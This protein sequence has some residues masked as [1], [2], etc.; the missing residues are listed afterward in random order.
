MIR[1]FHIGPLVVLLAGVA[2]A[3]QLNVSVSKSVVGVDEVF[4][5]QVTAQ[6]GGVS[7]P[8]VPDSDDFDIDVQSPS[9]ST[10]R[11]VQ[12]INGHVSSTLKSTWR[13]RA[14]AKRKGKF[15]LPPITVRIDGKVET[16]RDIVITVKD[17][18]PLQPRAA[19]RRSAP[20]ASRRHD[21]PRERKQLTVDDIVM[22]ESF[23][24][25]NEVYQ[26]ERLLL[27]WRFWLLDA[28]RFGASR[29]DGRPSVE[30]FYEGPVE[31]TQYAQS[32]DGYDYRVYEWRQALYAT[33]SGDYAIG[34]WQWNGVVEYP[35]PQT[36]FLASVR[37]SYR[38]PHIEVKVRPLPKRPEDFTGAVGTFTLR[39][40]LLDN[41]VTQGVPTTLIVRVVGEGNPDAIGAPVM[42]AL[43]W[44]HVSDAETEYKSSDEESEWSVEKA[45]I[46]RITPREAGALT[47]PP[48]RFV[49]FSP[50]K[51]AYITLE[52][53]AREVFV[54][55]SDE[56]A[57]LVIVGDSAPREEHSVHI[58]GQDVLAIVKESGDL[59]ARGSEVPLNTALVLLPP[60]FF[61]GLYTWRRKRK[62]LAEDSVYARRHFARAVAT[63]CLHNMDKAEEPVAEMHRAVRQY[64]ADVLGAARAGLSSQDADR[65]L[66]DQGI[67]DELRATFVK[68]LRACERGRYGGAALSEVE[69][70]ALRNAVLTA[71]DGVERIVPKE[72]R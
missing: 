18:A 28:R 33:G 41:V 38:T 47:I 51:E 13:Y 32:R 39:S 9:L 35:D 31:N 61:A 1:S 43:P 17:T 16:S 49:Y 44:G 56:N 55:P 23:V 65:L 19:G 24:D 67:P 3:G 42:P 22:I 54:E 15:T 14:S 70:E 57:D 64:L 69:V 27:T 48:I 30:G 45:F 11:S 36:G 4:F 8:K 60:V 29:P 71:I 63:K 7:D 20:G 25:K 5:I 53:E 6:G 68:V 37:R 46:Y 58:L 34:P 50:E 62:R 59:S 72:G 2:A 21:N 66:A 40:S 10:S 52:T 12:I 26:G